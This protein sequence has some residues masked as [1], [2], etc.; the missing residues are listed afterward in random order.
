MSEGPYANKIVLIT[1]ASAGIGKAT[2]L[3]LASKGVKVLTLLARREEKLKAVVE[4]L[5]EA[6]PNVQTLI[7]VGDIAKADD[8]KRAVDLTV[9]T[10]G[11]VTSAFLNAV[12]FAGSVDFSCVQPKGEQVQ[13]KGEQELTL[14]RTK[15]R[16][17]LNR[18]SIVVAL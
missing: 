5:N 9:E 11:G 13:P 1:G 18:V 16:P 3:Y 10:F 6:Y 14:L 17:I 12:R 15:L 4:E 2:A 8:N 7:V